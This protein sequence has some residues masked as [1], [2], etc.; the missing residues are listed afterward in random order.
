M[1][2]KLEKL[3]K[4]ED[5]FEWLIKNDR[6]N[7]IKVAKLLFQVE[8]GKLYEV[9]ARSFTQYVHG[10]AQQNKINVSTLWR[11]KSA[12]AV[13]M[14]ICGIS[15]VLLLNEKEVKATPEQLELYGKV[16][17]IAPEGIVKELKE[18]LLNGEPVRIELKALWQ[19]YR[20]LKQGKTERGRKRH[21]ELEYQV[22]AAEQ[23][24]FRVPFSP[25]EL[26]IN[27]LIEG[28]RY[29]EEKLDEQK[30]NKYFVTREEVLK[31][32][33]TNALRSD[34]WFSYTLR[35]SHIG[36]YR[37]FQY[38]RPGAF[39]DLPITEQGNVIDVIGLV[40]SNATGGEQ[41]V[42][43]G[44]SIAS[45]IASLSSDKRLLE[46]FEYCHYYYLAIPLNDDFIE[47]ATRQIS[48]KIGIIAVEEDVRDTKHQIRIVRRARYNEINSAKHNVILAELLGEAL[49]W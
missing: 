12:A 18:K 4:I 1:F 13:Y 15:E 45:N 32:N 11:A 47:K 19:T 44:A 29:D 25:L 20:P 14:E 2:D 22:P 27:Q 10:L 34:D 31:T 38:I 3:K 48:R 37:A 36:K 39:Q 23:A 46:N 16:R 5:E 49:G 43:F 28:E 21:I 7:W 8:E 26:D 30:R 24:Q 17:T 35:E 40:R 33:I 42:I 9:R 6:K 41:P